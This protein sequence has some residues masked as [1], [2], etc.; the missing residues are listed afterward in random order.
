MK[1]F[2]KRLVVARH[3]MTDKLAVVATAKPGLP[4]QRRIHAVAWAPMVWEHAV[5][6]QVSETRRAD[7]VEGVFRTQSNWGIRFRNALR[8]KNAKVCFREHFPDR[9][10]KSKSRVRFLRN[11]G[12]TTLKSPLRTRTGRGWNGTRQTGNTPEHFHSLRPP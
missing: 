9:H 6:S 2:G 12:F 8:E 4:D 1:Q 11:A 5:L 10:L 7:Y 3:Q